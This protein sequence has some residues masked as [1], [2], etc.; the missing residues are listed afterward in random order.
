MVKLFLRK[1]DIKRMVVLS[2]SRRGVGRVAELF[3]AL[4]FIVVTQG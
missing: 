1:V 2:A 3:K 4:D